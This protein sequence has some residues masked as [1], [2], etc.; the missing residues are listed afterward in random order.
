MR[1]VFHMR[2]CSRTCASCY[3]VNTK[4]TQKKV[5]YIESSLYRKFSTT[6]KF[7]WEKPPISG[8]RRQDRN[9][10]NSSLLSRTFKLHKKFKKKFKKVRN[11]F[12]LYVLDCRHFVKF[13]KTVHFFR[14]VATER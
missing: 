12:L 8:K 3:T 13:F 14:S 6:K 9:A 5:R 4:G 11:A 1:S 7:Q 10:N 2:D